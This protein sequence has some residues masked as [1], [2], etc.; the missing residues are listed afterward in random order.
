MKK[1]IVHFHKIRC[2]NI[3]SDSRIQEII[4]SEE[5]KLFIGE[6]ETIFVIER[7]YRVIKYGCDRLEKRCA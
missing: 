3:D 5:K 7:A 2:K 1:I 4:D 6:M